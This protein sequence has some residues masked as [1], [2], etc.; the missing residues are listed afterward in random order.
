[1]STEA[2]LLMV[3]FLGTEST[4]RMTDSF[5]VVLLLKLLIEMWVWVCFQMPNGQ[6]EILV[7]RIDDDVRNNLEAKI[8]M[9]KYKNRLN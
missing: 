4:A 7:R 9:N 8:V 3:A 1:M 5:V 6:N 2:V